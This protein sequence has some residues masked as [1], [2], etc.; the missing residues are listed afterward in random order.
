[1]PASPRIPTDDQ[2]RIE[3]LH[4]L[5]DERG[6]DHRKDAH[7]AGRV[8][9]PGRGVAHVDCSQSGMIT[10]L[11]KKAP[12]PTDVGRRGT[13]EAA[14]AE[15]LQID[16][17]VLLGQL[18][19]QEANEPDRGDD[20]ERADFR[21]VEPVFVATLVEHDLQCPDPDDE[22]PQADLVEEC[23]TLRVR[24]TAQQAS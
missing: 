21:A 20:A 4:R 12:K 22:Q 11:A 17:R 15:D 2:P 5:A 13:D 6:A 16:D 10:M 1:M 8:A 23:L 9:G 3:L 7:D 14:V 18:P 19:D 24:L